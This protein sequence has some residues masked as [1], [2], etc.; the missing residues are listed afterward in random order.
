MKI[1]FIGLGQMGSAMAA[2]LLRSGHLL[3]VF[4]RTASKGETL[5]KSGAHIARTPAEA[6]REAEVVITMVADDLALDAVVFG[7]EGILNSL[8]AGAVHVSCST[9]SVELSRRIEQAHRERK[10]SYVAAPV[11]GRPEAAASAKLFVVAGGDTNVISRLRPLFDAVG[12]RTFEVSEQPSAANLFKLCG[13]FMITSVI[14]SLSESFAL[15]RK[16]GFDPA[17][18]LEVMTNSLFSA[19][20]YQNYGRI[21]VE[22]RFTPAGF[23]LPLGL[24]DNRLVLAAA[25][26]QAVPMPIASLIRDHFLSAIAQGMSNQDWSAIGS[27]VYQNAGLGKE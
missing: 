12:Q 9:I 1:G 24:K 7:P 14:E 17:R 16:S 5:R 15:V 13:N 11:F 8:P 3:T 27:V 4:N 21:L 18:F 10:H 22:E 20:V 25:Q 19:P 2:N 23:A 26:E 6:A